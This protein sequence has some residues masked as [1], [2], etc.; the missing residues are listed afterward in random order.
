[1]KRKKKTFKQMMTEALLEEG[2]SQEFIDSNMEFI[3]DLQSDNNKNK[4]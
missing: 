3:D 4:N 2:V 1:M